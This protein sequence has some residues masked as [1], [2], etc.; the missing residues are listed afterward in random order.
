MYHRFGE[1]GHPSTNIRLDQFE[2]QLD[3]LQRAG[4]QILPLE[5]IVAALQG[6][7]KLPPRAVALTIDDAYRSVY[8]QAF[9]RL[10]ARG[11]P[12]T[13]FV[14]TD[15]VDQGLSAFMSWEQMREMQ[16]AGVGFANHSRD[17]GHLIRLRAGESRAQWRARIRANLE[18]AQRRLEEELG[19]IPRLFAYP[20]GEYDTALAALVRELGYV[21][22]GQQSGAV[23]PLSDLRAL[24]RFPMAEAYAD[25]AQ[26]RTKAAALPLP[27]R[28][29]IPWNPVTT[30]ARPRMVVHLTPSGARLAELRCY[31]SGQ[32]AIP[33]EWLERDPA[34]GDLR[35]ATRAPKPLP[36]GRSRYNC[37]APAAEPGRFYW[38]SHPWIRLR[39]AA[40]P[41]VA[42]RP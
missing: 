6:E 40:R 25:L 14:A 17:H 33:V 37:T 28:R 5:D 3:H 34:G 39:P 2:A 21:A 10:R 35:F 18:H 9:P 42:P 20:Y 22:F 1:P 29:V 16:A 23:G 31:A 32:G 30:L 36:M 13:V 12:F 26:F 24:P 7:K 38:F 41:A 4:Y 11:W 19:R 27:V 15:P 8:E